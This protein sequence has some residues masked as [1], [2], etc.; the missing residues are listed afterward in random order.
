MPRE[1]FRKK[2]P[3]EILEMMEIEV[4]EKSGKMW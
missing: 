1:A 2:Q 4:I 3:V